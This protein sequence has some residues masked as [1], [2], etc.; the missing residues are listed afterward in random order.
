MFM[1][2][3]DA[4]EPVNALFDSGEAGQGFALAQSRV[5]KESGALR[6]E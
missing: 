1:G 3:Q 4:V 2:N 5:N 6:L